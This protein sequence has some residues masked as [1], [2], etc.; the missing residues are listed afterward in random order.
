MNDSRWLLG[1]IAALLVAAFILRSVG[2]ELDPYAVDT[3][4]RYISPSI[5]QPFGTD[6]LGRN[7]LARTLFATGLSLQVVI[8]ALVLSFVLALLLGGIAGLTA[9]KWPDVLGPRITRAG[10]PGT[11]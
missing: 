9:G 5:A 10:S 1:A 2:A 3:E 4:A 6:S 7:M 11:R 8:G